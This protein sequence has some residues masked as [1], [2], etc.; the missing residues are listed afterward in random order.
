MYEIAYARTR[1]SAVTKGEQCHPM[2]TSMVKFDDTR[3]LR[4]ANKPHPGLKE[5]TAMFDRYFLPAI[6]CLAALIALGQTGSAHAQ[7]VLEGKYGGRVIIGG[8]VGISETADTGQ[9][10]YPGSHGFV[11]GYGFYPD[12]S[13]NWPTLREAIAN[14]P[15]HQHPLPQIAAPA[16]EGIPSDC[17]IVQVLVPADAVLSFSGNKTEQPGMIRRFVT[18]PLVSGKDY[19]YEVH[20]V[21]H[22]NGQ[23]V[24]RKQTIAV[25]PNQRQTV[26]FLSPE[27]LP[28]PNRLRTR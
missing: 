16:P 19:V 11:P 4:S 24:N 28:P 1:Q 5:G 3:I 25:E 12:Y 7:I 18:P 21:W 17:A 22:E 26:D 9:A 14:N 13:Y 10:N 6:S 15:R 23:E 2:T 20:A 8:P 27:M